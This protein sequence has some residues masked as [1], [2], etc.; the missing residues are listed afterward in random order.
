M[1]IRSQEF[2]HEF[3]DGIFGKM[4]HMMNDKEY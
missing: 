2:L 1:R 3:S 4:E